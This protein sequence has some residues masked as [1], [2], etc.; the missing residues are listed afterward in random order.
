MVPFWLPLD[1]YYA[2]VFKFAIP[3]LALAVAL[4]PSVRKK[5]PLKSLSDRAWFAIISAC[6]CAGGLLMAAN[7]AF[8]LWTGIPFYFGLSLLCLFGGAMLIVAGLT[9]LLRDVQLLRW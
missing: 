1:T 7:G 4:S 9:S 2:V 3:G 8:L 6:F 5:R